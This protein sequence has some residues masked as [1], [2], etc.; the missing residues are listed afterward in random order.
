[1][2][3]LLNGGGSCIQITDSIN[4]LNYILMLMR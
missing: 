2:R 3:L 4:K 1:M